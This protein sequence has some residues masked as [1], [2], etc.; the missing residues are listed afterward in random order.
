MSGL[1]YTPENCRVLLRAIYWAKNMED[2][3]KEYYVS[4]V[5]TECAAFEEVGKMA[6]IN[7]SFE[8][9]FTDVYVKGEVVDQIRL[10]PGQLVWMDI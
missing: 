1:P 6:V 10:H 3:M 7:N 8:E 2:E 5:Y 4:N 9:Q